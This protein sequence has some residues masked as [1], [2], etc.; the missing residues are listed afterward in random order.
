MNKITVLVG[1]DI[2]SLALQWGGE[3]SEGLCVTNGKPTWVYFPDTTFRECP[4]EGRHPR[5]YKD[6]LTKEVGYVLP[7]WNLVITT[8]SDNTINI[9]CGLVYSGV[10]NPEQIVIHGLNEKNDEIIF[11]S[12]LDNDKFYLHNWPYG[13]MDTGI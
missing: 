5:I 4:E 13:F 7:H 1:E 12:T 10:L 11:T 9:L 8:N 6:W 3:P 2:S